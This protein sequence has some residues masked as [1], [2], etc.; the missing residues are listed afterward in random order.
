ML[1]LVSVSNPFLDLSN[2]AHGRACHLRNYIDSL[3]LRLRRN[4]LGQSCCPG[5]DAP[6]RWHRGNYDLDALLLKRLCYTSPILYSRYYFPRYFQLIEAKE[7]VGEDNR[8][9]LRGGQEAIM[10]RHYTNELEFLPNISHD[11]ELEGKGT[12]HSSPLS[13]HT[14]P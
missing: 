1:C 7:A 6:R 12:H 5:F 8:V 9:L 10:R 11:S 2:E 4:V 14:R 13:R 3:A